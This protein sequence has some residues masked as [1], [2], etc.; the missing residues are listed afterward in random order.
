M[1]IIAA[2]LPCLLLA[3][4]SSEKPAAASGTADGE[5]LPG[6]VSDAMIPYDTLRSEG[7]SGGGEAGKADEKASEK[8]DA[9]KVGE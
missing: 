7:P 9:E 2:L 5:V 6:S 4:C 1:K 3:A 8:S